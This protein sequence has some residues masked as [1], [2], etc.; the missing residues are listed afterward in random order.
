MPTIKISVTDVAIL[1]NRKEQFEPSQKLIDKILF[2]QLKFQTSN[3]Q[4]SNVV[5]N[6]LCNDFIK[7]KKLEIQSAAMSKLDQK[8]SSFQLSNQVEQLS[9]HLE[10]YIAQ[11]SHIMNTAST[12]TI[13]DQLDM[14]ITLSSGVFHSNINNNQREKIYSCVL[15]NEE[16]KNKK[17]I[18]VEL[19]ANGE[20]LVNRQ[21]KRKMMDDVTNDLDKSTDSSSSSSTSSSASS[22]TPPST[23]PLTS[24]SPPLNE[25]P[26]NP[27]N[28]SSNN[29]NYENLIKS[30]ISRE[31]GNICEAS[32][33]NQME[34]DM[35][36]SIVNRNT[37]IRYKNLS[38][39]NEYTDWSVQIIGKPDGMIMNKLNPARCDLIVEVKTRQNKLF[40]SI[41]EYERI[42]GQIYCQMFNAPE[43][44][45]REQKGDEYWQGNIRYNFEYLKG[46]YDELLNVVKEK[47][48]KPYLN[49]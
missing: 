46:I 17:R 34:K 9:H 39:R 19:D 20:F 49:R 31:T 32:I 29:N 38:F 47:I 1:I 37:D 7:N 25:S 8:L 15:T 36:V 18:F 27:E 11:G 44:I 6:K 21:R 5:E 2:E 35:N 10:T 23:S 30:M 13:K 48:I 3:Q 41:P 28:S 22:S 4:Y 26:K 43:C 33:L 16:I 45:L 24:N 14:D 42:Q 40:K 12:N